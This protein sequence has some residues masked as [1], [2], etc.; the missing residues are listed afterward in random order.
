MVI[1]KIVLTTVNNNKD[2]GDYYDDNGYDDND[3]Y[4]DEDEDDG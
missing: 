4:E 1:G 2:D 3:N